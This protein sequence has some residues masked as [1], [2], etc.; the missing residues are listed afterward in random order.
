[1]AKLSE[2][3]FIEGA[4]QHGEGTVEGNAPAA[5]RAYK[6]LI[7]ALREIRRTPDKGEAFLAKQLRSENPSVVTWSALHL[8]PYRQD[9]AVLALQRVAETGPP[10][11]AFGAEM[12][13]KEWRAGRLKID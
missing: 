13:L 10:L 6:K 5:N 1:M 3:R 11:I 7:A 2:D 4:R 12:T 9:E 8:L